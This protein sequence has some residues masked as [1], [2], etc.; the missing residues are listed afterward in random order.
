MMKHGS[1]LNGIYK[2][3]AWIRKFKYT[4]IDILRNDLMVSREFG[5]LSE[6][7]ESPGIWQDP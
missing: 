2:S 4:P 1:V 6:E 7:V 5:T 3:K